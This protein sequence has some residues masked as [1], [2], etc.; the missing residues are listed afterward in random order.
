L[1]LSELVKMLEDF[2]DVAVTILLT[3][4]VYKIAMLIDTVNGKIKGEKNQ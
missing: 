1:T 4:V 2:A 3:Y